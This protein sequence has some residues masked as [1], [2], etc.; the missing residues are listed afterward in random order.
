MTAA[1]TP[2][3][4]RQISQMRRLFCDR[5]PDKLSD[6]I[7]LCDAARAEAD[8][9]RGEVAALRKFAAKMHDAWSNALELGI[10]HENHR[11]AAGILR[12]EARAAQ[13]PDAERGE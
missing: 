7:A 13:A 3:L 8:A 6:G 5:Q 12:D 2:A 10:I 4:E 9:L 1:D 11:T